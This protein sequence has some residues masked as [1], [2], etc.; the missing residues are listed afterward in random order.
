MQTER[1]I[2]KKLEKLEREV[3]KIKKQMIDVDTI[4]TSEEKQL[5]DDSKLHEKEGL[6]ASIQEIEDVRH[7]I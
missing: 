1:V 3:K 2:L 7:K 5:L 4:L 6:L